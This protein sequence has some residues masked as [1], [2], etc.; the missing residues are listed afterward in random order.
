MNKRGTG[1][2]RSLADDTFCKF[3]AQRGFTVDEIAAELAKCQLKS[4]RKNP[5]PRSGICYGDSEELGGCC[6]S[7]T[8]EKPGIAASR[9]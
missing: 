4:P 7:W 8:P 6:R 2:D 3:A 5:R 9:I 1:P